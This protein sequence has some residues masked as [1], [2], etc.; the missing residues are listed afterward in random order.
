MLKKITLIVVALLLTGCSRSTL[1]RVNDLK[2]GLEVDSHT[3]QVSKEVNDL[4]PASTEV[5]YLGGS[6]ENPTA[7]TEIAVQ[8]KRD[9]NV[10]STQKFYGQR[11]A[12]HPFDFGIST[13]GQSYFYA[14]LSKEGVAW[15]DGEYSA[16]VSVNNKPVATKTFKTVSD[17]AFTNEQL[18]NLISEA[19]FG[20]EAVLATQSVKSAKTSFSGIADHIYLGLGLKART[21]S[22]SVAADWQYITGHQEITK[23]VKTVNPGDSQVLFDLARSR[24][25]SLW[26][27]GKWPSGLYR[28]TVLVGGVE[29][30][31]LEFKVA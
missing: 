13:P 22:L 24:F 6:V 23:L 2:L 1:T 11:D 15:P 26:P 7:N 25:G 16:F 5:V 27:D 8:W 28:V 18:K 3:N 19:E 9:N 30:K 20:D 12:E 14:S 31:V 29:V 17:V 21:D 10:I 4:I